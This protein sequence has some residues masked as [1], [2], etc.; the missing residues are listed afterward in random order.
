MNR[1]AIDKKI[2]NV[3][4]VKGA[5]K[6]QETIIETDVKL[7]KEAP[8]VMKV[9]RA[10]NKKWYITVVFFPETQN[11]FAIFCHTNHHEKTAQ[12]NDAVDRLIE[13][14]RSKGILSEHIMEL[15]KKI[16]NV[17]NPEKLTRVISLLL[18]HGVMASSIVFEIDKVQGVLVTSLLFQIKKVL[19][20]F[21]SDGEQVKGAT[22]AECGSSNVVYQEGCSMCRDCGSSKCG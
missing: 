12:T 6:K 7:P 4:V 5:V 14:A 21:I 15:E 11:P 1:I 18:R 20:G 3:S 16:T 2:S 13:L 17:S 8:A 22:C 9:L 10:E 19:S